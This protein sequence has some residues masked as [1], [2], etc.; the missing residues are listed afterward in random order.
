LA[1]T[2]GHTLHA[3]LIYDYPNIDA[4]S[5]YLAEQFL[6]Q[7]TDAADLSKSE[8]EAKRWKDVSGKLD[9][10]AQDDMARLL[11]QSLTSLEEE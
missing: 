2:V 8:K 4:L 6:G 10:L 9:D 5:G 11:A 3:S 7:K 1:E